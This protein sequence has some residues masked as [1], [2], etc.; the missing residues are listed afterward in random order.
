MIAYSSMCNCDLSRR[1]HDPYCTNGRG[2]IV[3]PITSTAT[4]LDLA[5]ED[6]VKAR[7][8]RLYFEVGLARALALAEPPGAAAP[9]LP[10]L[11]VATPWMA[12]RLRCPHRGPPPKAVFTT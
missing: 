2:F 7:A 3:I 6:P 8:V 11:A 9:T 10:V 4:N 12:H 5:P 1:G